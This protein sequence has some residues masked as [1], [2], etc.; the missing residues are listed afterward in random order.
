M[1]ALGAG[2]IAL[3]WWW[4][5]PFFDNGWT[6]WLGFATHKPATEDYVP[7]LPWIGVLLWGFAAGQW[8]LQHRAS[9]LTGTLPR[10]LKPLTLLGQFSL[11]I[12]MLHQPILVGLLMS[13]AWLNR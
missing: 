5:H 9:W 1:L 3:P 2:C 13:I 12:Y 4:Q 7:L 6:G 11:S 10:T 8:V